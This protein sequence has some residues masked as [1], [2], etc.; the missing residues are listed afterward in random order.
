VGAARGTIDAVTGAVKANA[1]GPPPSWKRIVIKVGTSSL[2]DEHG[3]L[4]PPLLWALARGV[5]RLQQATKGKVVLVSS[6]AGAAGREQLKISL[7]LTV[8][9]KQAAAAVGQTLLML[10][11]ARAFA[12]QPVAQL[13]LTAADIQNRERYVNA[14]NTLLASLKLGAIPVINENDSVA[15]SELRFGDNDTLS[16]WVAHLVGADVLVILTD[17]PGL[18]DADPRTHPGAKRLE[19]VEDVAAVMHLAGSVGTRRGTGG[20]VTKLRAAAL[21]T[22]AGTETLILGGGGAA[23]EALAAGELWGTRLLARAPMA[24]RKSWLASQPT[25]GA[26]EIDA[27]ALAALRAGRSL[28]PKGV[29]EVTGD[30]AFGDAVAVTHGGVRVGQGLCN[31][32]SHALAAIRGRHTREIAGVL[33]YKDYDEVIHRDNLV[34]TP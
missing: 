6:G 20:M 14:K 8:P 23:L 22:G 32:S 18:Y 21:A 9:D 12:P 17:V 27:G 28:L 10:E 7:P 3:R 29:A 4:Y 19:V 15:T 1:S 2:T 26:L 30:F 24:A 11:W 5:E 34:L 16:A 31:Y 33:G 13:L 25:R